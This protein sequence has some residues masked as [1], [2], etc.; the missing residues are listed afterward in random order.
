[1]DF[2]AEKLIFI[3]LA[4]M[5]LV[6]GQYFIFFDVDI[7]AGFAMTILSFFLVVFILTEQ[8]K[9]IGGFLR[10][11]YVRAGNTGKKIIKKIEE[12]EKLPETVM[13]DVKALP[14]KENR[15]VAE[16]IKKE[17]NKG[18][19]AGVNKSLVLGIEKKYLYM[20]AG[21]IFIAAQVFFLKQN[22][23]FVVVLLVL[24]VFLLFFLVISKESKYEISIDLPDLM[25]GIVFILGVVCLVAGWMMLIKNVPKV[26][27][28]GVIWT[29][30]GVFL[31]YFGLPRNKMG[32]EPQKENG[33]IILSG[34]KAV[35]SYWFKILLVAAGTMM[36]YAGYKI[37]LNNEIGMY[38]FVFFGVGFI[39]YFFAFPLIKQKEFGSDG[40]FASLI[41][42]LAFSLAFFVAYKG[43][44]LFAVNQVN[45]AVIHY[46][47]AAAIVIIAFPVSLKK[48][49][50][51][52]FPKKLEFLILL[53]IVLIGVY[54]RIYEIDKRPFGI[55]NDEASALVQVLKN[56]FVGQ[57]PI[58][59]Y[60]W[61]FT[62]KIFGEDRV[63][64]RMSGALVGII[65]VPAFYFAVRNSL[66]VRTAIFATVVFAF[67]RW[68]VH[69]GRSGHGAVFSPIAEAFTVYFIF[70]ALQCRTK[71]YYF[72]AGVMTGF[73][74]TGLMTGWLVVLAPG[75][76]FLLESMTKRKYLQRNIIGLLAFTAGFWLFTSVHIK[77]YFISDR[78]YF[79][80]ISEVS[81]FSKDSNAP[82][83]NPAKGIIDNTKRVLL[84][85]NHIGDNR[86]RNSGGRPY[87][88]SFDFVTSILFGM[89]FLYCLYYSRYNYY[90]ILLI[91][92]FSQAAG[93]IFSIE[94]P[95]AMRAVG[96][97]V[98][99]LIFAAIMFNKLWS[100]AAG[101][102]RFKFR[103]AIILP[104]VLLLFLVPISKENYDQVFKRWVSGFDELTT[105]AGMYSQELGKDYRIF[106]YTRLYWTGHP[107]YRI[108]RWDYKV[109][110]SREALDFFRDMV[111]IED[112]HY[113]VFFHYDTWNAKYL[114]EQ[115]FPDAELDAYEHEGFGK[116]LEVI[117]INNKDIKKIRGLNGRIVRAGGID[118]VYNMQP[119][120]S[121]E[122]HKVPYR[123]EL[124]GSFYAPFYGDYIFENRGNAETK[125]L[126]NGIKTEKNKPI[127]L[128]RGINNIRLEAD[129]KDKR[130]ILNLYMNISRYYGGNVIS[131]NNV[132]LDGKNVF[133]F[134]SFGLKAV[135][136]S[137]INWFESPV[138][139]E[140]ILP[141][142]FYNARPKNESPAARL[143][144][145]YNVPRDGVYRFPVKTNGFAAVVFNEKEYW[146]N[147]NNRTFENKM[148]EKGIVRISDF[149]L[150]KGSNKIEI[151]TLDSSEFHMQV[152]M[153]GEPAREFNYSE[154]KPFADK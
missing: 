119:S 139:F 32:L 82:V 105:A 1:M 86:P 29:T 150:K 84:M 96:T 154:L 101:V 35:N 68:N 16:V 3:F 118:S 39:C 34:N 132:S 94:A 117:K 137:G 23:N 77:N 61:E 90:F 63:G 50:D 19:E 56:F 41:K 109:T 80:R 113:A 79:A 126:V 47:A 130:D 133:V 75:A 135:Y 103:D 115:L 78:I 33:E 95:S 14:V 142:A 89:G 97:M 136:Y 59:A 120:F 8:H 74:W 15:G 46:L 153:N 52:Y 31:F 55:E 112:E 138:N 91:M 83:E 9:K 66:G 25:Q 81:V 85:F 140:E 54:L 40:F 10:G 36:I 152:S 62:F 7:I 111:L 24:D 11:F 58:F 60:V 110:A 106:L 131:R 28:I 148:D 104:A 134:K 44:K 72:M 123:L 70:K 26:Q 42:L 2:K 27:N 5:I 93:S 88:P 57:H 18:P 20:L 45:D 92:F 64:L 127:R 13:P 128:S 145:Y 107:P 114:W 12:K 6:V 125:I 69:Y 143:S 141:F 98:P 17:K 67:L 53:A 49:T 37:S 129:R 108:Y 22:W 122:N 102:F 71:F 100:A 87:E 99:G 121:A 147:R 30:I 116:L 73:C 51:E 144:G 65:S 43:Q 48:K 151:Y 4:V 149:R 21:L 124:E 38:S 76:Y 146:A